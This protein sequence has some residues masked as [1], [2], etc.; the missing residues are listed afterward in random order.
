MKGFLFFL[1]FPRPHHVS[2]KK[3]FAIR[4]ITGEG[5]RFYAKMHLL[6]LIVLVG[7]VSLEFKKTSVLFFA[8]FAG[9]KS[10]SHFDNFLTTKKDFKKT[11]DC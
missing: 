3:S 7:R 9:A 2:I 10:V 1:S 5:A 6:V 4:L 11:E 8:L